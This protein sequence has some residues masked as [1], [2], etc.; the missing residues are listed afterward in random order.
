L[1]IQN[2]I[3]IVAS[4]A[5]AYFVVFQFNS[6]LFSAL[7]YVDGVCWIFLPS[8]LR[9]VF[10][11]LFVQWGALGIAL[12]S[13]TIGYFY[14]LDGTFVS[15]VG[16]GI[17]SG[18]SPWLARLICMDRL[19]LDLDLNSLTA[20]K[21]LKV[22]LLFAVLSS[23]LHQLW[24]TVLGD[25]KDFISNTAVMAIGDFVGTIA[26]LYAAK[27]VLSLVPNFGHVKKP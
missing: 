27:V 6:Y 9:L 12:A 17:I 3:T 23:V 20:R 14:D 25:S 26:V 7:E 18:F 13:V 16:T 10:I 21:L 2:K 11:L 24:F 5:V 4:T 8:G 19:N 15:I 22:S 1:K